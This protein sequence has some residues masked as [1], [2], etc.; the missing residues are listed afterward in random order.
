MGTEVLYSQTSHCIS[1]KAS[2]HIRDTRLENQWCK[3]RN[4]AWSNSSL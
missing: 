2:K 4:Q 3:T 1:T